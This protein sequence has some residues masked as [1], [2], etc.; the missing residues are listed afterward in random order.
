ME[1]VEGE[2]LATRLEKGPLPLDQVLRIRRADRRRARQGASQRSH[3]PRSEARQ[4]HADDDRSEAA[5]FRIGKVGGDTA[6]RLATLTAATAAQTPMTEEGTIVGTFQYMSPEQLEGKELD[7]RS[8][9]FSLGAVL[10]E[11]V[12][13]RRA[14]PGRSALSVAAAILE[15]EPQ[16]ISEIKPL[17]P[18]A[19]DHT[20]AQCLAKS[21]S[22]RWQVAR[23]LALELKW[24]AEPGALNASP[25]IPSTRKPRNWTLVWAALAFFAAA[26]A[27]NTYLLWTSKAPTAAITRF[28]MTLPHGAATM[29]AVL[30]A[31]STQPPLD[32][33][34]RRALRHSAR[35]R[36][37]MITPVVARGVLGRPQ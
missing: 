20:I 17:A 15:K 32:V 34:L 26:L 14:F 22:H 4:H 29:L 11:M 7:G 24:M 3:P 36:S 23:D 21:V 12:T 35:D 8:D 9:I 30:A 1:Y 5:G 25:V 33:L 10:Y 6:D 27:L 28:E 31:I 19:L 37:I 2:T 18:A 16:P 13:G